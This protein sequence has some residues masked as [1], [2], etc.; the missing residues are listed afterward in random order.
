MKQLFTLTLLWSI[1]AQLYAASPSIPASNLAFNIIEGSYLNI[2]WT[3]GNGTRRVIIAR[4]GQAVT[5]VP[6]NGIDYEG[7]AIF[8][9]GQQVAAGQYVVYDNAFTS[10]YLTGLQP[11]TQYYFA[12]YEYNGTGANTEYLTGAVLTGNSYT[13]RTPT[14]QASNIVF[15]NIKANSVTI[16]IT[17]GNGG[18]RLIVAREGS[19]V[20]ASPTNLQGYSGSNSFGSGA[21]IGTG[22]YSVNNSSATSVNISNLKAGTTYHFAV[23]E[24]N[25][26]NEPVY[27]LP[28]A[29]ANVTTRTIPTNASSNILITK[30]DG[31]ELTLAWTKGNG[32]RRIV[33]AK[34]GTAVTAVPVNGT[35]YQANEN[36]G[37]GA[38]L[39]AGEYV[40]YNDVGSSMVLSGLN[41]A[42]TYHFRIYEFD[43]SGNTTSYLTASYASA[44]GSTA[45]MPT[46]QVNNI[47]ASNVLATSLSLSWQPGNGR[48]RLVVMRKVT[49]VSFAPQDFT[50]YTPNSV[51]GTGQHAGDGNYIISNGADNYTSVS[52]LEPNSMYHVAI[53]EYNGFN[54][55]LYLSPAAV[56]SVSTTGSLPVVLGSWNGF[57]KDGMV[58]LQWTT[59]TEINVSHFNIQRSADGIAYQ[60]IQ[61]KAAKG[62]SSSPVQYG[63]IDASPLIGKA[64][65]RL[66]MVD[67][68]GSS[69][70]SPVITVE[71]QQIV[72][73]L[74]LVGNYHSYLTA[75]ISG[76]PKRTQ[77][78]LCNSVG[79]VIQSAVQNS[80]EWELPM[81]TLA[82]GIYFVA[83]G[84]E[85]KILTAR[86]VKQ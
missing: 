70:Y 61:T 40:V 30:T 82:P 4:V 29:V 43:G 49:A 83:A 9:S 85:G 21:Q 32:Q 62:N 36:F 48:A 65:Y 41:A 35:D 86:F 18:R 50:A 16:G 59:R 69:K 56:F 74:I 37:S 44:N 58:Q 23:Y 2:G 46:Q 8:G 54:Q 14:V 27:L 73:E 17:A 19:A 38:T 22:N 67:K 24:Y 84:T 3:A 6:Q 39:A 10:F 72:R 52:N 15:S 33:V 60:S 42:T 11:N 51:F 66:E 64:Y 76:A 34:Q 81:T 7:N 28:A 53:F 12:V 77:W 20:N 63:A 31:K 75:R 57:A 25:G 68:D 5:A 71:V 78:I 45:V 47:V 1:A 26:N 79:Q 80:N 13:A 55:P